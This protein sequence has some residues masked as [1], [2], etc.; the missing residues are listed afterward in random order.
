MC[1][2]RFC[3]ILASPCSWTFVLSGRSR[4]L[5]AL[6]LGG[7]RAVK[8]LHGLFSRRTRR[9]SHAPAVICSTFAVDL[10]WRIHGHIPAAWERCKFLGPRPN[11]ITS[12]GYHGTQLL[13]CHRQLAHTQGGALAIDG[14][15]CTCGPDLVRARTYICYQSVAACSNAFTHARTVP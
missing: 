5:V 9:P 15:T 3:G 4:N 6:G 11:I 8:S 10:E 7:C 14:S 2:T 13:H 1:A 12:N